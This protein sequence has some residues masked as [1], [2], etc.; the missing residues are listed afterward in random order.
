MNRAQVLKREKIKLF[1]YLF[2]IYQYNFLEECNI[3]EN[4]LPS[5]KVI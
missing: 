4:V 1:T 2:L 5:G 3:I